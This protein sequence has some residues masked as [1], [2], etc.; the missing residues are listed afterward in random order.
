MT[1]RW[2]VIRTKPRSETL[3][4]SALERGGFKVFFP[5]VQSPATNPRRAYE[6]LFPGYI[7]IGS[8][9][10]ENE[11]PSIA[12][13]PGVSGWV[14]FNGKAPSVSDEEVSE[15]AQRVDR[16]SQEGGLWTRFRLG[17]KVQVESGNLEGSL[18]KSL[19]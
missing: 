12:H 17:Q 15:L 10:E 7:F 5:R 2:Y 8:D 6:S 4:V 18:S 19:W 3:A 11:L 13:M 1:R 14:R 9:G 16:L